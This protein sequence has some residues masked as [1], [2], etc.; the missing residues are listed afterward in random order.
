M[1]ILYHHRIASKDG[2]Y[3]HI[4]ELITALKSLGHDIVLVEPNISEH[5]S[6][7]GSSY[8]VALIRKVLPGFLHELIEL[9]Y[10]FL[11]F[12]KLVKAVSRN[13]PDALY[14]RY[15]LFLPSGIWAKKLFRL[16]L[17]LEVNAPLYEERKKHNG[18]HLDWLA[19]WTES[20]V[21]RQADFVL[22][23]TRVLANKIKATGVPD[24]RLVVIPNG[25]NARRFSVEIDTTDIVAR[26]G[27]EGQLVL[28]FTGFVR[29]WH[30][31]DRVLEAIADNKEK[32]W[33]LLLVGDGPARAAIEKQAKTLGIES[34]VHIT[35]IVTRDEV[36]RYV[37][38]FDVALQPDVVAYASPLKLFEYMA[39]SKAI[40][41]PDRDNI[42]EILTHRTDA[43]LFDPEDG[44]DFISRLFEL[45]DNAYLRR[46]LGRSAANTLVEKGL[47]WHENAKKVETLLSESIKNRAFKEKP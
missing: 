7:G 28:G 15:N 20:Y 9:A 13:K 33:H 6:F 37:S 5:Q 18:I 42:R 27:L 26:Y 2:Q 36:A 19:K 32:N 41:A 44:H 40:L 43:L 14:E 16:P 35:G 17:V 29:E 45:C 21:W 30:R 8:T 38:T 1:K 46:E 11:D 22:P 3:V 47:Y 34:R 4:E 25:I 31:L 10:C 24:E 39:L 12:A 23:V